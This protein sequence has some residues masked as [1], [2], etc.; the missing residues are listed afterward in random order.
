MRSA[1]LLCVVVKG[2]AGTILGLEDIISYTVVFGTRFCEFSS[3]SKLNIDSDGQTAF[4]EILVFA[5]AFGTTGATFY[6]QT[7][8]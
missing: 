6:L 4:K 2:S 3:D 5:N 1:I 8:R 7:L